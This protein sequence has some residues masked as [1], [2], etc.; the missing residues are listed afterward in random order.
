MMSRTMVAPK[1]TSSTM[2]LRMELGRILGPHRF[3]VG[4]DEGPHHRD[5]GRKVDDCGHGFP[6][7]W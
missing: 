7:F 3:E 1:T 2:P 5:V 6:Q 4:L